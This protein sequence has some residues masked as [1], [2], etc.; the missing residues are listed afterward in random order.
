MILKEINFRIFV[1]GIQFS[2][3]I[4]MLLTFFSC[5]KEKDRS[6]PVIEIIRPEEG[7]IIRTNAFEVEFR[8][9]D[10]IQLKYIRLS[11]ANDQFEP[12]NMPV[13]FYP[14][15]KD[16]TLNYMVSWDQGRCRYFYGRLYPTTI[17]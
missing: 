17:F 10:D 14:K 7:E 2:L 15:G 12:V 16:T 1:F 4:V 5:Q 6:D 11:L 8:V 9:S 13:F 3:L